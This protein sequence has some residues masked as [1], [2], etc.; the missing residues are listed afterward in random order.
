MKFNLN[1]FIIYLFILTIGPARNEDFYDN[2]PFKDFK[3]RMYNPNIKELEDIKEFHDSFYAK[4]NN[5]KCDLENCYGPYG[6]CFSKSICKCNDNYAHIKNKN[7]A[8]CSY[9][10]KEQLYAFLIEVIFS[11]GFGHFYC[12]RYLNFIAKFIIESNILSIEKVKVSSKAI[13]TKF[14][15]IC[16]IIMR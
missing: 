4:I 10:R 15:Y 13:F 9:K 14:P 6:Y 1:Y 5:G 8:L 2:S 7:Y 12:N 11:F 16:V 3:F